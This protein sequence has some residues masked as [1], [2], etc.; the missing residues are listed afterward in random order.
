MSS[1]SPDMG[2]ATTTGVRMRIG[3]LAERVGV[4]TKTVR[5]YEG[6]GLLPAPERRPSGYRE[7]TEGDVERLRFIRTAQRLGLSL[8]EISEILGFRER[9]ERPCDYV[10]GVLDRQVADLDR[11]MAEMARLR[12]ELI[13][14]KQAADRLPPEP[15]CYCPVIE[16]T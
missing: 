2:A 8:S 5:Y 12:R 9:G 4:N 16:H 13:A 1:A 14:L 15:A 3:Q 10:L 6:I 11:R 7:Y